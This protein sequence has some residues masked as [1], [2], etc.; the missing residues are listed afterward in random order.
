MLKM[1]CRLSSRKKNEESP[2]KVILITPGFQYEMDSQ[3]LL[4]LTK[5][6]NFGSCK[7]PEGCDYLLCH[8]CDDKYKIDYDKYYE[9]LEEE[10][11]TLSYVKN[12]LTIQNKDHV[13]NTTYK[14][15]KFNVTFHGNSSYNK[16]FSGTFSFY[17]DSAIYTPAITEYDFLYFHVIQPNGFLEYQGLFIAGELTDF[18]I[19]CRGL[20][21][22]CYYHG[23]ARY[24]LYLYSSGIP[25]GLVTMEKENVSVSDFI[26]NTKEIRKN[27]F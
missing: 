21:S 13:T 17:R 22:P 26:K 1:G 5:K 8:V 27:S 15:N 4:T 20:G 12:L 25:A 3:K 24:Y 18:R 6:F 7:I 2:T 11:Y 16:G 10:P 19:R 23:N 14:D 9:I